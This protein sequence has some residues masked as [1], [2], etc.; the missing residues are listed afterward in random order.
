MD[1]Y[2][3]DATASD[4]GLSTI[5]LN[6]AYQVGY[7]D[8]TQANGQPGDA[9]TAAAI[10]DIFRTG[11]TAYVDSQA[12]QRG[13]QINNPQYFN[14]GYPGGIGTPYNA[15]GQGVSIRPPANPNTTA[16]LLIVAAV[17][18]VMLVAR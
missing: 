13:Y 16:L 4:S 3:N 5:P 12:I 6:Y 2:G 7:A 8:P 14:A 9:S 17:V 10:A 1:G 15:T 11:V 18:V